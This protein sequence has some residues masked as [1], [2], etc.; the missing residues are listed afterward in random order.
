MRYWEIDFARGIAVILMLV[1]H[2][3]FDM[4]YFGKINLSFEVLYYVP[5]FIASMFIFISGLCLS[6]S[7]RNGCLHRKLKRAMKL[8]SLAVL[9]TFATYLLIGDG[10]VVF[11]ILHFFS[12]AIVLG[13]LFVR[14]PVISF[15]VG[16][17]IILLGI[18]LSYLR[19]PTYSFL[20]LGLIPDGFYTLDYVP[21]IPW[22]G[23]FLLGVSFGSMY[24]P[25][26]DLKFPL[27]DFI[28]LL[29]RNSLKIYM[30]Q[31]PIIVL[32]LQLYYGDIIKMLLN[33]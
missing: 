23:V 31:H 8:L 17:V 1:Y 16:I 19:F 24:R 22:F 14:R 25:L 21:L 2:F 3:L 5:R 11:G 20:W 18:P 33:S 7:Y 9:I 4:Y 15:I 29:G 6:I 27:R 10:F 30:I 13:L 26:K 12:V 28:T 32:I